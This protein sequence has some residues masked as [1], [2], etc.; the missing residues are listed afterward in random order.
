MTEGAYAP[1]VVYEGIHRATTHV[2]E[3]E[4]ILAI[5]QEESEAFYSGDKSAEDV[6]KL[7]QSRVVI[8]IAEQS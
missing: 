3:N 4:D 2:Q 5:V 8:Y 7:I 1:T 6:A